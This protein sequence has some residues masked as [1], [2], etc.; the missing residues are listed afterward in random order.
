MMKEQV[1]FPVPYQTCV[2]VPSTPQPFIFQ[3][4]PQKQ[5]DWRNQQTNR[6]SFFQLYD[7]EKM[8][9]QKLRLLSQSQRQSAIDASPPSLMYDCRNQ[10][11]SSTCSVQ[12]INTGHILQ[13]GAKHQGQKAIEM[14][15]D[16]DFSHCRNR[17]EGNGGHMTYYTDC[18]SGNVY[19]PPIPPI[20]NTDDRNRI[21]INQDCPK[22]RKLMLQT[23]QKMKMAQLK[24]IQSAE[25]LQLKSSQAIEQIEFDFVARLM[26]LS[27]NK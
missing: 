20:G 18:S 17:S 19:H 21:E 10:S 9:Q 24:A 2:P 3:E 26:K 7:E 6:P 22:V 11:G 4:T 23:D 16:P 8:S 15:I 14:T 27:S 12:L 5:I 13:P 1:T 25:V